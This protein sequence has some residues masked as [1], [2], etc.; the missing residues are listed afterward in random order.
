MVLHFLEARLLGLSREYIPTNMNK[1]SPEILAFMDAEN[2]EREITD[3]ALFI[4]IRRTVN[5]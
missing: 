4:K 1:I 2:D 5:Q 3:I